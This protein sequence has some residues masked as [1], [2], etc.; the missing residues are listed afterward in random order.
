MTLS[1]ECSRLRIS[2]GVY[3]LGAIEPAERTE[4]ESHLNVCGRCRDELASLAGLPALLSRVTEEQLAQL[5]PPPEELFE[6]VLT[7]ANRETRTR[8]RRNIGLLTAAAVALVVVTGGAVGM[9]AHETA[10]THTIVAPPPSS[11][12]NVIEPSGGPKV[13]AKDPATGVSAEVSLESKK[14]G[15]LFEVEVTGVAPGTECRLIAVSKNGRRD[16]AGA[17]AVPKNVPKGGTSEYYGSSM[18]ARKQLAAI[19]VRTLAGDRLVSIPL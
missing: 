5:G 8:R 2:L 17:W 19:E 10:P 11:S 18:I 7:Q 3:V 14:W 12:G 4:L 6:S 13:T 15:T 9:V 16:V 1:T